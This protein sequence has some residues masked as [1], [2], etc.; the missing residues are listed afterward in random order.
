MMTMSLWHCCSDDDSELERVYTQEYPLAELVD[1]KQF[2]S[3][4]DLKTRLNTVLALS[5]EPTRNGGRLCGQP[6]DT[7]GRR[8]VGVSA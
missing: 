4:E 1:A 2:K 8:L 6:A 7:D 3:Y 5:A